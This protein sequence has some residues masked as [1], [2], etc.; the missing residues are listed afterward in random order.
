LTS[1]CLIQLTTPQNSKPPSPESPDSA[2]LKTK[3]NK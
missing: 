1:S 3:K 2:D